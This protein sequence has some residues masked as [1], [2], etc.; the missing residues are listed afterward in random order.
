MSGVE[1]FMNE[2]NHLRLERAVFRED[3]S[4][5]RTSRRGE[6]LRRGYDA[7]NFHEGFLTQ[8][9][10]HEP[11]RIGANTNGE[12]RRDEG[13]ESDMNLS[14]R[15]MTLSVVIVSLLFTLAHS[16]TI[17]T[18]W[19]PKGVEVELTFP[20]FAFHQRTIG[21]VSFM[22]GDVNHDL[23]HLL[24]APAKT[25]IVWLSH[26]LTSNPPE[27]KEAASGGEK[28]ARDGELASRNGDDPSGVVDGAAVSTRVTSL[29]A[30][31]QLSPATHS[32]HLLGLTNCPRLRM[33]HDVVIGDGAFANLVGI[34]RPPA[35]KG[36]VGLN[37]THPGR[38]G[39]MAKDS[40]PHSG[41]STRARGGWSTLNW[42]LLGVWLMCPGLVISLRA[43]ELWGLGNLTG[44]WGVALGNVLVVM[45]VQGIVE[46]ALRWRAKAKECE[47]G[48]TARH[49]HG[50]RSTFALT[51]KRCV[52]PAIE[53]WVM[54]E[55][56]IIMFS[57]MPDALIVFVCALGGVG[58]PLCRVVYRVRYI[59]SNYQ[60]I[61]RTPEPR[62]STHSHALRSRTHLRGFRDVSE[63]YMAPSNIPRMQPGET[64]VIQLRG[65]QHKN[66]H[67]PV[68]IVPPEWINECDIP[69]S[70][71]CPITLGLISVPAVTPA[72]ITYEY[73]A[74]MEWV[75]AQHTEPCTKQRLKKSHI[76][77]NLNLRSMIQDWVEGQKCS[78][79]IAYQQTVAS[80]RRN[81]FLSG[82]HLR[83]APSRDKRHTARRLIYSK[84]KDINA[85]NLSFEEK[86]WEEYK[87]KKLDSS[88]T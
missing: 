7:P 24:D 48:F 38:R 25:A 77:P 71:C 45:W 14:S 57:A 3:S 79:T 55:A 4:R 53:R 86:R 75:S 47:G 70:F 9:S 8:G 62:S 83:L 66:C 68:P 11:S 20:P 67:W 72:G 18:G 84:L 61:E 80:E 56:L 85:S 31:R 88:S 87:K 12:A 40:A 63:I 36:V 21:G 29:S 6:A 41:G 73:S 17:H 39:V 46:M 74:L 82:S 26:W 50:A 15:S 34:K 78:Y 2:D 58:L 5:F 28:V 52:Y 1:D 32:G 23:S 37:S 13:T 43:H 49:F 69:R 16:G 81:S 19:S 54:L 27:D 60:G 33:I 51:L 65:P 35:A 10:A 42:P 22:G 30:W 76:V 44:M 64:E 59:V